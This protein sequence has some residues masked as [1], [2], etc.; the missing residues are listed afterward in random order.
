[1]GGEASEESI[2]SRARR[3]QSTTQTTRARRA[4]SVLSMER[5]AVAAVHIA[6]RDGVDAVSM[7]RIATDLGSGTMSL[8]RHVRTKDELLDLMIDT[9]V[10]EEH[11]RSEPPSGNWRAD[12]REMARVHRETA[13]RHPWLPRL[14]AS[15]PCI[16][17][18]VLASTEASLTAVAGLGLS[19]DDMIRMIRTVTAFVQGYAQVELAERE[20]WAPSGPGEEPQGHA[21]T[22]AYLKELGDSGEYPQFTRMVTE[23]GGDADPDTDFAWQ[24]ER[25]LDGLAAAVVT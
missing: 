14:Q 15:R 21:R 5:I 17:P 9:V 6:D 10:G 18:N 12:L 16:G 8:Y 25:V 23:A 2:W 7:R 22:A 3:Q 1:M 11:A 24:L 4:T 20:L 13:H 19:I